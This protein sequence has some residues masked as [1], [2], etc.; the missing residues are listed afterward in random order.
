MCVCVL[1]RVGGGGLTGAGGRGGGERR[2][3]HRERDGVGGK[4]DGDLADL[5]GVNARTTD[6][7]C[8]TLLGLKM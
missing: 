2:G 1:V 6:L 5:A 3:A 8:G 7:W 4:G